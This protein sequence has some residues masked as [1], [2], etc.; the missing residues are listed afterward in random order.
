MARRVEVKARLTA[1]ADSSDRE[2]VAVGAVRRL[3]ALIGAEITGAS[4]DVAV[5]A[6]S[7][8]ASAP[9]HAASEMHSAMAL[10]DMKRWRGVVSVII[11]GR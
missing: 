7:D 4:V 3:C 2:V 9:P 10:D 1:C 11:G 8:G 5:P 6:K